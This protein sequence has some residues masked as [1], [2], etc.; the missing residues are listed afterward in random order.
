VSFAELPYERVGEAKLA[1]E[2]YPGFTAEL[3][4]Q[5]CDLFPQKIGIVRLVHAVVRVWR[6]NHYANAVGGGSAAHLNRFL[7][8]AC[9]IVNVGQD[10]AVNVDHSH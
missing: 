8:T 1:A 7:E 2:D 3:A 5:L 10:V 4:I 6:S 9:T